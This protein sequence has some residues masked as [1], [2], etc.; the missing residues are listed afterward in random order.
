MEALSVA[1]AAANLL[2]LSVHIVGSLYR[3]W[4]DHSRPGSE[5]LMYEVTRLRNLLEHI[6]T[7]SSTEQHIIAGGLRTVFED[8]RATLLDLLLALNGDTSYTWLWETHLPSRVG[9]R[10]PLS[11]Q[12]LEDFPRRLLSHFTEIREV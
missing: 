7:V 11:K 1:S 2:S 10:L 5:R 12:D 9:A 4:D 3:K 8:T 6:E